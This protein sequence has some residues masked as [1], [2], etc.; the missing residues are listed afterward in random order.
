MSQLHTPDIVDSTPQDQQRMF[1]IEP[2][3]DVLPGLLVLLGE[4]TEALM[5]KI[6]MHIHKIR[7]GTAHFLWQ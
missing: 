2:T 7:E 3:F 1:N 4:K 6:K 5:Q